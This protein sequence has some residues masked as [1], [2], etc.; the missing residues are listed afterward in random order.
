MPLAEHPGAALA[1]HSATPTH[2]LRWTTALL[3]VVAAVLAPFVLTADEFMAL[4]FAGTFLGAVHSG[5]LWSLSKGRG[6]VTGAVIMRVAAGGANGAVVA[7]VGGSLVPAIGVGG[8]VVVLALVLTFPYLLRRLAGTPA[9]QAPAAS[10]PEL[11]APPLHRFGTAEITAAWAASHD[12]LRRAASIVDRS[13]IAALRQAYLDELERRD[14]TGLRRWLES[15]RAL[16]SDPGA[17]LRT[18]I[19]DEPEPD[20]L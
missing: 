2:P 18:R 7:V 5:L 10:A 13:H 12:A 11:P 19:Q 4:V 17:F 8:A 14:A 15:G 6:S 20:A 3:G 1:E 16:T 9:P